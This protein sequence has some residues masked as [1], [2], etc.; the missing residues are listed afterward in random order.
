MWDPQCF[1]YLDVSVLC[2]LCCSWITW[3]AKFPWQLSAHSLNSLNM[4][5]SIHSC[6]DHTTDH[7]ALE[8]RGA[9]ADTTIAYCTAQF[10]GTGCTSVILPQLELTSTWCTGNQ[11]TTQELNVAGPV[12]TRYLAVLSVSC[13]HHSESYH[14]ERW[15][16][17]KVSTASCTHASEDQSHSASC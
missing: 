11:S 12:L 2:V 7:P 14:T 10:S 6:L 15:W 9:A 8:R 17:T 3:F 13:L 5:W 1:S 16:C 4:P